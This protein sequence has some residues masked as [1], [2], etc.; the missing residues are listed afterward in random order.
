[1]SQLLIFDGDCGFCT[2]SAQ[3]IA[4]H[5]HI[6]G[7]LVRPHQFC[8][9]MELKEWGLTRKDVTS[10]VWWISTD[11]PRGGSRAV[12]AALYEAGGLWKLVAVF[13]DAAPVRPLA[14]FGYRVVARYR[15]RLPGG[16]PACR[17]AAEA[18]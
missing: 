2:T 9:E 6:D 12:A 4:R 15:Y 3:W 1:M 7:P 18:N 5:W 14:Q 10:K 16:T 13:I 8:S 17:L 11:R